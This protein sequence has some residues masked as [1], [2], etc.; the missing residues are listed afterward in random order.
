MRE[1]ALLKGV[2]DRDV[3]VLLKIDYFVRWL[4]PRKAA[5]KWGYCLSEAENM[6]WLLRHGTVLLVLPSADLLWWCGG[7]CDTGEISRSVVDLLRRCAVSNSKGNS[8]RAY[9]SVRHI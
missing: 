3:S 7:P 2:H 6:A 5:T 4:F 9:L 8:W 1:Q